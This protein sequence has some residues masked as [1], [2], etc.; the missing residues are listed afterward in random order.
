MINIARHGYVQLFT[1][2]LFRIKMSSWGFM[3]F[4]LAVVNAVINISNNINNNNNNNNNN[5]NDNNNNQVITIIIMPHLDTIFE[6][7]FE[8]FVRCK[9]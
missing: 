8:H 2:I 9:L 4:A 6:N 1:Y 3:A 5:A 7:V